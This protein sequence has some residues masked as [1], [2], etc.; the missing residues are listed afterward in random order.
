MKEIMIRNVFFFTTMKENVL[1][2]LFIFIYMK[3]KV[4]K[5]DICL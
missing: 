1:M 4:H 3:S 2:K 5:L